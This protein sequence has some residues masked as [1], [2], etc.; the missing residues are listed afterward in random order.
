[1]KQQT[2][3]HESSLNKALGEIAMGLLMAESTEEMAPTVLHQAQELTT[4]AVGLIGHLERDSG[5]L[6]TITSDHWPAAAQFQDLWPW[7]QKN[8]HPLLANSSQEG[9]QDAPLLAKLGLERLLAVPILD[10]TTLMGL[11]AV[12]NGHQAYTPQDM[13]ALERLAALY[14]RAMHHHQENQR[15]RLFRQLIE[16]SNDEERNKLEA[17]LAAFGDGLTVQDR[18]FNI[19]YQNEAH[20]TKQGDHVGELCYHAYHGRDQVCPG[21]LLVRCFADGK[22]HR[23]ETSSTAI[24]G[25]TIHMEVSA[26]PVRDARGHIY[27]GIETVRDITERMRVEKALRD[28]ENRYRVLFE[29]AGDAIV[30]VQNDIIME[31]NEK[32]QEL[33]GCYDRDQIIKKPLLAFS[34]VTQLDDRPAK[35]LLQEKITAALE[36]A[37]QAFPWRH[38]RCNGGRLETEVTLNRIDLGDGGNLLAIIRD[39]TAQKYAELQLRQAQ[40]MESIGTLAGGIAHDFNNILNAIIGYTDLAMIRQSDEVQGLHDDLL[41][42]RKAADRATGLVRQILT[43]S[44]KQRQEKS[45]LQVSLVVKEALKLLRASIPSTIE[46]R[47]EIIA[48]DTVLADPTEIH[49]LIMNLC[50][51]AFQAMA[52]RGGVLQVSLI[53]RT[54]PGHTITLTASGDELPSGRYVLL[55]VS[56][57]GCGMDQETREKIFDPY[58]TTK[59]LGKG[60]GLG[61]AV[62]HG[63]VKGYHGG[64]VVMSEPGRGT[65]FEVYLPAISQEASSPA[66]E[67]AP[68]ES[69][70]HE[71]IMVVDDEL[72]MRDLVSQSLIQAGYRVETFSNGLE[73][74]LAL[75]QR[76]REWDLLITDQTMPAMTGIQLAT[77]ALAIRPDLPIILSSGYGSIIG[78][79]QL[80]QSGITTFLQKPVTRNILLTQVATALADRFSD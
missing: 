65:T 6:T 33:F 12:A 18:Q 66:V 28:S 55:A 42:V 32:A 56:D 26:S 4:S 29:S 57:T 45:P 58:F 30:I 31:C 71:R 79:E 7:I 67:D 63:I 75:A 41:Q 61:L 76:P 19:L 39:V 72:F 1:M 54:V 49:Q 37:T 78:D 13:L 43:F 38:Q 21:C 16:Q 3:S 53:T 5:G 34:A 77:K 14:A 80:K 23:R 11:V 51:N 25:S 9:D 15:L 44:R 74:W 8:R 2:M 48:Q 52:D 46:I 70:G 24:D 17:V 59:E 35:E 62:A 64:I 47:Q 22:I 40:K 50:T 68:P 36:G 27:A 60:T 73:A 20:K 10:G 69:R